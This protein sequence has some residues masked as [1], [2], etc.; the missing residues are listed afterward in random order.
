[1]NPRLVITNAAAGSSD[2]P[3][4]EA[5]LAVLRDDGPVRVE[6]TADAEDLAR[7]LAGRRDDE[8]VVALGGDGSL[9]AL[10]SALHARDELHG[11]PIGL[12]PLGTGNDFAR[13]IGLSVEPDEAARQLVDAVRTEID[14]IVDDEGQVTVNAVHVGLGAEAGR[15]ASRWKKRLGPIGYVVGAIQAGLTAPGLHLRIFVDRERLPH[16]HGV[17]MVAMGNG[18]YVGAGAQLSPG[19]DPGDGWADVMVSYAD[20]PVA[21]L[22]YALRLRRGEHALREDVTTSR[23]RELAVQGDEFW[24]NSDGEVSGPYRAKSWTVLP[25]AMVMMLPGSAPTANPI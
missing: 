23:A 10:V 12:I 15:Q 4:I 13:T 7:V 20:S 21:R 8:T 2:A 5:A 17:M 19:A 6:E 22:G 11:V 16:S 24:V 9:H 1:M 25:G 18:A 14:L 3:S